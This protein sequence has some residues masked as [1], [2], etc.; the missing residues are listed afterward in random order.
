MEEKVKAENGKKWLKK[1]MRPYRGYIFFLAFLTVLST[2]LSLA[3]AYMVQFLV[4]SASSKN[5]QLLWI[6]SAV[7]LG[8]LFVRIALQ[9]LSGYAAEHLRAKITSDLR[10]RTFGKILRSD[11]GKVQGYHSGEL[12]NRLTTDIS[13]VSADTVGLLPAIVGMVVQCLG[14]IVALLTIDPLFTLI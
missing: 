10:T 2:G 1:E 13:E 3:F 12:L 4:N 14:A 5:T 11:Y 9:T 8:V 7:L 6:F